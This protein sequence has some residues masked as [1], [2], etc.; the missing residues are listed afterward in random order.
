M[1]AEEWSAGVL[2][3]QAWTAVAAL[4]E[5]WGAPVGGGTRRVARLIG[6]DRRPRNMILKHF[7]GDPGDLLHRSY[8]NRSAVDFKSA[9]EFQVRLHSYSGAVRHGDI[10]AP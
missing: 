7:L 3:L 10:A 9:D 2:D 4:Q 1:K 6:G 8:G 5:L